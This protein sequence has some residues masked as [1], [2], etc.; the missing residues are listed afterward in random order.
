M[1][2]GS[3]NLTDAGII[4]DVS[5]ET[6]LSTKTNKQYRFISLTLATGG[7]LVVFLKPEQ[8]ELLAYMA[9][10]ELPKTPQSVN[11]S[12]TPQ[13]SEIEVKRGK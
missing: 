3:V 4:T 13:E 11:V 12:I 2:N 1:E 10:T 6:K 8:V 7:N 9:L 5:L